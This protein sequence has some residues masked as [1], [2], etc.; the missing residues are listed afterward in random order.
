MHNFFFDYPIYY[1]FIC[2]FIAFFYAYI[3][4]KNE[5]NIRS[6][7][8]IRCLFLFRFFSIIF[9]SFLLLNPKYKSEISTIE[10]PIV[11]IAKDNSESLKMTLQTS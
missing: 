11:I 6:I 5:K 8:F 9:I 1:L 2:L 7:N 3:L 10:K 4:Y